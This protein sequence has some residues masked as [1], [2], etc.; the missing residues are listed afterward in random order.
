MNAPSTAADR[1]FDDIG[2]G[3]VATVEHAF[4]TADVLQFA[5]LCGDFSPLHV[6][7]DYART[8]EFGSCVVH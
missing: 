7:A 2:I 1:R 6:D 4:S 8:T 5:Q 3:E